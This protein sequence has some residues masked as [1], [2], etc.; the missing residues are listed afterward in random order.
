M[1]TGP[2]NFEATPPSL[3][4]HDPLGAAKSIAD[5]WLDAVKRAVTGTV[6]AC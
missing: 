2:I 4:T 5:V 3:S 1:R 6:Q